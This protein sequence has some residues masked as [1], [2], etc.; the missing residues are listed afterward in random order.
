[1]AENQHKLIKG[2]RDL[3]AEEI[4]GMNEGKALAEQV[5]NLCLKLR[6][7]ALAMPMDTTEQRAE[8]AE[9]LRWLEAGEL[10]AQQAFMALIRSIA[11]PTTF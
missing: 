9:A 8:R 11:R 2:Y 6:E 3:T 1:M 4:A 10:Q 7:K 5:G